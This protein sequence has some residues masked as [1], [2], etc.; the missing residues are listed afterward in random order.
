MS[1][2]SLSLF[3]FLILSLL[4]LTFPT[5]IHARTDGA[6]AA[7]CDDHD[8]RGK[9]DSQHSGNLKTTANPFTINIASGAN[10]NDGDPISITVMMRR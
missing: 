4:F 2:L 1:D 8:P 5:F 6:D 10:P 9:L 7:A 3:S